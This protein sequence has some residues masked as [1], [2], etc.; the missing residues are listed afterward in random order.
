MLDHDRSNASQELSGYYFAG[1]TAC[2][3]CTA[4]FTCMQ[5]EL[6]HAISVSAVVCVPCYTRYACPAPLTSIVRCCAQ[7]M[8]LSRCAP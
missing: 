6:W 5:G 2:L 7:L 8:S 1:V 4:G 3:P